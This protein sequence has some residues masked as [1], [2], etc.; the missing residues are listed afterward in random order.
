MNVAKFAKRGMFLAGLLSI[1]AASA[2][3]QSAVNSGIQGLFPY[4][5]DFENWS[6]G[7]VYG[8]A[9]TG[10]TISAEDGSYIT[11]LADGVQGQ[12]LALNTEGQTL[13]ATLE[14][15]DFQGEEIYIDAMVKF[16]VSEDD[17]ASIP[18][19]VKI[20]F[21]LNANSNLV[22]HHGY[23]NGTALAPTSTVFTTTRID[24]AD[25]YRLTIKAKYDDVNG[26]AAYQIFVNGGEALVGPAGIAYD[27]DFGTDFNEG[28]PA[29]GGTWFLSAPV[30][31]DR[32]EIKAI[33]FQGTGMVDD[34]SVHFTPPPAPA[35]TWALVLG[36]TSNGSFTT[37]GAPAAAGTYEFEEG[38]EVTVAAVP[39]AG[40]DLDSFTTNGVAVGGSVVVFDD[41]L[42]GVTNTLA[43][44]FAL[45]TTDI[46]VVDNGQ[47]TYYDTLSDAVAA[48]AA[49][50]GVVTLFNDVTLDARV[51]PNPGAGNT[52]IID[53][54]GYTITRIG[55]SG[56]GSV[57]DVKSGNVVITNGVIDCTQDDTDI[58]ADGVYAIT[59]RSGANVTLTD[60]VITVDS[61][62]GACAYPFAGASLTIVSGAYSNITDQVYSYG[63][64]HTQG[65]MGMAVNQANVPDQLVTILGGSFYQIDPRLG[66]D[67]TTGSD[68][69][70]AT[71]L[72]P[73]VVTVDEGGSF[74]V[75]DAVTVTFTSDHGTAPEA[76]KIKK[77]TAASEPAALSEEGWTFNGWTLNG[78]AYD[79]TA[80]VNADITLVAD[81]TQD[82]PADPYPNSVKIDGDFVI[83][84]PAD[85][86]TATL[87]FGAPTITS[88]TITVP[89][90]ATMVGAADGLTG[91]YLKVK[92]D[93]LSS[94]FATIPAT[95]T[96]ENGTGT[97]TFALTDLANGAT[98]V[99]FFG[100]TTEA[101]Q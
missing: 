100:F 87:E 6:T 35:T 4:D 24:P 57:F 63:A 15:A 99:F 52:L 60:L 74:V 16:V 86:P 8:N 72:D 34:L 10:W 29:P 53:L 44:T 1:T 59:A 48:A 73:S 17:P 89:F 96:A 92:Y 64:F 56:N 62:N 70:S 2:F 91:L 85:D 28:N 45:H 32:F 94:D 13:E 80:V 33:A 55:T 61:Q 22:V 31:S 67:S 41:V 9:P 49:N 37:N 82:V 97:A 5:E 76:Q 46:G 19:D 66:D 26:I 14:G 75:Y 101:I 43:A 47:T 90:D 81:W 38:Y 21:W 36:A 42:A 54:G 78:A 30:A 50:G 93:L 77:G 25:F 68:S 23:D 40:Y 7:P 20:A 84:A 12:V 11:N 3:A 88:S 39:A 71:F 27:E 58:V 69:A 95:I 98:Q 79:F 83:V 18:N 65:L 51:E